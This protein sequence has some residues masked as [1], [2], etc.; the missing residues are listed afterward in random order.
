MRD[1]EKINWRC[2]NGLSMP[3]AASASLG[4]VLR[5]PFLGRLPLH[6]AGRIG[7]T[8]GERHDVIHH[9]AGPAVRMAAVS[10]EI[11]LRRLAAVDSS[12]LAGRAAR[13]R[14]RVRCVGPGFG[15]VA[16]RSSGA[17]ARAWTL[18]VWRGVGTR[19]GGVG[20]RVGRMSAAARPAPTVLRRKGQ[21]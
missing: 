14:P 5:L 1:F 8:T 16:P 3:G 4:L 11:V 20:S 21:G 2:D 10:H 7:A 19:A 6:V 9:M 17:L 12:G 15:R 18:D 13:G